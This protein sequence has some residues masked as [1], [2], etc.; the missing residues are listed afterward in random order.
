MRI[1][2]IQKNGVDIVVVTEGAAITGAASAMELA[3]TV[4]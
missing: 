4:R 3:M 1:E 2:T